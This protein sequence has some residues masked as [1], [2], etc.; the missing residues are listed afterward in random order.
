M[1]IPLYGYEAYR[2]LGL[3]RLLCKLG[4]EK[5]SEGMILRIS[6]SLQNNFVSRE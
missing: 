5:V 4:A 2:E 3:K 1:A 6:K